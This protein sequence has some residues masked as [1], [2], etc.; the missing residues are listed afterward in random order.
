M[1]LFIAN[2]I[3]RLYIL[4]GTVYLIQMHNW[5]AWW[6]LAAVFICAMLTG[7]YNEGGNI[8]TD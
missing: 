7:I 6:V 3:I 2:T 1:S 4:T 5:S 8:D